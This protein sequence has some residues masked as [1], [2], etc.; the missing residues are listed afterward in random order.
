MRRERSKKLYDRAVQLIPGGVDS[1]VRAFRSV[2]GEPLFIARGEGPFVYDADGHRYIDY[3]GSW[4]PL[5]LGHAPEAVVEAVTR[6]AKDGTSFGACTAREID[7]AERVIAAVPSVERVRFV[8]SGTEA[9]MSAIRVAR[10]FTGR[11]RVVKF[12]GCYHGHADAFLSEAGSGIATLGIPGSAGVPEG[13]AKDML[14]LPFNDAERLSSLFSDSGS[15]IAAIILEPIPCNMGMAPPD[16]EFLRLARALCDRHGA[17]LIFDEVITG[18]RVGLGGAQAL[19]GIRPDL[20]TFGKVIGGGLPV[21]AYGGRADVMAK[22]A[23]LGPV[24]QAGTLSGNPLAMAAGIATLDAIGRPGFF[25]DLEAKGKLFETELDQVLARH[26]RPARLA[27][28]GSIFHLWF[29]KGMTEAPRDYEVL[30]KAD[31][32]AFGRFFWSL[33]EQQ[34]YLAPSAFEVGFI[35]AAHQKQHI[36]ATVTAMDRALGAAL[37]A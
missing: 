15:T 33:L 7:L 17:L 6:A 32:A 4:G 29:A 16:P 9:T 3:V 10:G 36:E 18:F 22:I 25:N 21:G 34:V 14:T 11:D 30:K 19:Y 13:T 23:P 5:I 20:T 31:A 24:Y 12:A 37:K 8:S 28:I 1:P 2:G 35:S 26:G 27:R